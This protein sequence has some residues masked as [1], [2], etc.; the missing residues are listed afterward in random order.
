MD[1]DG[2]GWEVWARMWTR[3]KVGRGKATPGEQVHAAK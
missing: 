1:E 3:K 2:V